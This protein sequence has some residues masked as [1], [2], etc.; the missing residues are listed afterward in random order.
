MPQRPTSLDQRSSRNE[1]KKE[2]E[3]LFSQKLK[4][5]KI[6]SNYYI[7]KSN[8]EPRAKKSLLYQGK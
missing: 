3:E 5:P 4:L 1:A 8:I 7:R 2:L 6:K